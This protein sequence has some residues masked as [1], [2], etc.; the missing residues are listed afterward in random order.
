MIFTETGLGT[1]SEFEVVLEVVGLGI[2][3]LE[4]WMPSGQVGGPFFPETWDV[5]VSSPEDLDCNLSVSVSENWVDVAFDGAEILAGGVTVVT[6]SLNSL[7]AELGSG[8][9]S[10]TVTFT[11]TIGNASYDLDL[12]LRVGLKYYKVQ[13]IRY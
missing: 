12:V 13:I 7:A 2:S 3:S 8:D 6:F 9:H 10:A 5:T 11:E 4:D 1:T